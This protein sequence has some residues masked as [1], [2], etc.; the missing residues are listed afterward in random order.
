MSSGALQAG[1]E[2][3]CREQLGEAARVEGLRRLS[4]G[5]NMETWAFD[6]AGQELILRRMPGEGAIADSEMGLGSISLAA[7]ADLMELARAGGVSV[8]AV[9]AR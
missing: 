5:A 9:F 6:C 1:L 2:A 4:G 7:Q 3:L 8:P